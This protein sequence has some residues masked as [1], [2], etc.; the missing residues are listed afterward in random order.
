MRRYLL[1]AG[2]AVAF[3]L[4]A[5]WMFAALRKPKP[6]VVEWQRPPRTLPTA[7]TSAGAID[8]AEV[9]VNGKEDKAGADA[10]ATCIST[11]LPEGSLNKQA[12]LASYCGAGDLRQA[13]KLLRASFAPGAAGSNPKGWNELGWFELAALV[14][15]RAGC[16]SNSTKIT[17]P[18][19]S[20]DCPSM[21]D[22]LETLGR[23]VSSTQ[24]ADAEIAK[25]KEAAHC[26]LTKGKPDMSRPNGE[27]TAAAERAFRDLFH[28]TTG[29]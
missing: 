16:C 5:A 17:W 19:T 21:A 27:P 12:N 11:F 20:A 18:A 6:I 13:M 23:A 1:M 22:T 10:T 3:G 7:A 24:K 25:F 2:T 8:L 28:V 9:P 4:L 29:P 26:E 14:T 15:L